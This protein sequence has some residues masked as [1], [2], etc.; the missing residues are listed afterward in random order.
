MTKKKQSQAVENLLSDPEQ[1]KRMQEHLYSGKPLLEKNGVFAEMLQKLVNA[2]L[3]GEAASHLLEDLA[4]GKTNKLNGYT[5]KTVTSSAGPLEIRTP[6]D[7]NGD[8]EP[9]LIAKRQRDL[10]SG[11]DKQIL[12]LYAQ[13]NSIEDT[14][15]LI[16]SLFS[17]ELSAGQISAITDQVL[18][19]LQTWRS[20]LLKGFYCIIYLD[21]IHFKVR[22]EG[23]YSSRAFYTVYGV[24]V[25][26]NRDLLGMYI[27]EAEG[28]NQWGMVLRDIQSRGVED[29]LIFCTDNLSGFS[30]AIDAVYPSSVVQKC[31]VHKIRSSTRFVDDADK[32]SVLKD[33]RAIYSSSTHEQALTALAAFRVKW[34]GKYKQLANSWE[35][36]W[37][38]LMAFL[39]YPEPMRRMIYTTNPVEALHRIIRKLIKGKAAWVSETALLKQIYLS[40]TYNEKSWK[41]KAYGW[42]AIQRELIQ[43]YGQ[44][45][46]QHLEAS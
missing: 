42:K 8:F 10:S 39:D 9:Q 22:H 26:G 29:V 45:F 14:R 43:L 23:V 19:E 33:L 38:E 41:K 30:E 13:G 2:S 11:I 40:L 20:R 4:A 25:D 12:A 32:K 3:R 7:R 16:S 18:P 6:R 37:G 35:Q 24:D 31:V 1:F 15:R 34:D 5:N 46:S 44:R 27:S 17:V 36:D 21:A 28:A